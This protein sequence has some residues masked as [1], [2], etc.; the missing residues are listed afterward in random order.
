MR[1]SG[2]PEELERRRTRAIDL[3]SQGLAPVE[4]A[5]MLG[6][7][8]RSVRRWNAAYRKKGK[9]ALKAKPAPGRPSELDAKAKRQVEQILLKGAQS[10]GFHTDLW[11]CP[12]VAQVIEQRFGVTYH[13]DHIGRLLHGLGWSPQKPERR[14]IER[15]ETAIRNWVRHQWPR[16]KKTPPAAAPRSSS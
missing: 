11:T 15:D 16:V 6:V 14:A 4:V 9:S 7:E 12:R 10:A 13:V 8:R 3:L 2:S 1:P 5:H